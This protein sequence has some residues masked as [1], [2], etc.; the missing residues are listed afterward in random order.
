[1]ELKLNKLLAY[2][3]DFV[4][5]LLENIEIKDIKNIILFGSVTREESTKESD[6]DIF[7]DIMNSEKYYKDIIP[8]VE[9]KFFKSYK[10][11]NYW[12][13]KGIEN[14]FNIIIGR[15]DEWKELKNSIISNGITLYSKFKEYPERGEHKVLFSFERIK[16]E[17][18]RVTLFKNLFGYKKNK[19]KYQGL[20]EKYNGMKIGSGSIIVPLEH[21]NIF[22]KLFKKYLIKVKIIKIME[23]K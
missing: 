12:K 5:F 20:I 1:M 17:S 14:N 7:V 8:K 13:L 19:K 22:H 16:P 6:V 2:S 9:D 15:L 10:F 11:L 23:Y 3:I 18:K 4:S 21:Q